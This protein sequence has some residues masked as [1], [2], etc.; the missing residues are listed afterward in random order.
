MED[1][2]KFARIFVED[3][4]SAG[5]QIV[6]KETK[7]LMCSN[8]LTPDQRQRSKLFGSSMF[9]DNF[10]FGLGVAVVMTES[11]N[12]SIPCAGSVGSVGWPGAYGGWWS[13]DPVKKSIAIFLTHS[14]TE[15]SQLSQGIGWEL[16][17]A[18]EMFS[19]YFQES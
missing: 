7:D 3:G 9:R 4:S 18:I 1:Y 19:K 8:H 16:Y 11:P 13:A 10:G 12:L 6:K 17:E 2:L 15:P 5:I 14:M